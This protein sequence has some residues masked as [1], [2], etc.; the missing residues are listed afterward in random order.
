MAP[1]AM[2]ANTM[3][4]TFAAQDLLAYVVDLAGARG[5]RPFA[6]LRARAAIA[7]RADDA[8][9][10]TERI[11]DPGDVEHFGHGRERLGRGFR[12]AC[13]APPVQAL[14]EDG[15]DH[16]VAV[17]AVRVERGCEVH[18]HGQHV[19]VSRHVV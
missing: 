9:R 12:D 1:K 15:I 13:L 10:R 2:A 14:A 7:A 4:S 11:R 16:G 8:G 6:A 3:L 5:P 18:A 19:R 17:Y